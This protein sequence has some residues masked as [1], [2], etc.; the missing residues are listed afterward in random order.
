MHEQLG[1]RLHSNFHITDLRVNVQ[2][3]SVIEKNVAEKYGIFGQPMVVCKPGFEVS[4]Q[5]TDFR[6]LKGPLYAIM[7]LKH[8]PR[9]N[10]FHLS[11]IGCRLGPDALRD[12]YA[13][14]E[15]TDGCTD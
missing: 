12:E 8:S 13:C 15:C 5:H 2:K 11:A 7:T 4:F 10:T 3:K 9:I 1:T 14:N 6:H